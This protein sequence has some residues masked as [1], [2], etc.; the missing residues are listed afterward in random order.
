MTMQMN[1]MALLMGGYK[2]VATYSKF[3]KDCLGNWTVHKAT[4]YQN[5]N[6]YLV[7]LYNSSNRRSFTLQYDN[8]DDANGK[9]KQLISMGYKKEK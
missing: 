3:D 8:K 5:G 4:C 7:K 6:N 9:I 2:V 1:N